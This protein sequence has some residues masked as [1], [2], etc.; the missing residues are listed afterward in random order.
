M[1][2]DSI[3]FQ[4]AIKTSVTNYNF[5]HI[6]TNFVIDDTEIMTAFLATIEIANLVFIIWVSAWDRNGAAM[7]TKHK[8]KYYDYIGSG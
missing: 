8:K 3:Y 1:F 5:V 4:D 6:L 7:P 2:K